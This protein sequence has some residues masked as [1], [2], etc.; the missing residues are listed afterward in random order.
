MKTLGIEG[1]G[2]VEKAVSATAASILAALRK[3]HAGAAIIPEITI[4]DE[5]GLLLA[6]TEDRLPTT[7]RIDALMF[8]SLL[9]TAIE[10]KVSVTDAKRD[11]WQKVWPWMRVTHRSSMPC[12]PGSS[13][14]RRSTAA[15][16][17]GS[18][19]TAP[20]RSSAASRSTTPP[21]RYLR[22]SC[23]PSPTAPVGAQPFNPNTLEVAADEP[24]THD[25]LP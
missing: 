1:A 9:R 4:G 19:R 2:V 11:T 6:T 21:S 20:S 5:D 8:D 24:R 17:G 22:T 15:A 10:I 16:F 14:S 25:Q 7:R 13:R 12:R 23:R 3:H 18:T